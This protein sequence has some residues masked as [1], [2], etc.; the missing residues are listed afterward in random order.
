MVT[1]LHSFI[2][3]LEIIVLF[4]SLSTLEDGGKLGD[5]NLLEQV[6]SAVLDTDGGDNVGAADNDL[7][8][9]ADPDDAQYNV[10]MQDENQVWCILFVLLGLKFLLKKCL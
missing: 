10:D 1:T 3:L 4:F 2:C 8:D 7:Q 5:Y 6:K 9:P